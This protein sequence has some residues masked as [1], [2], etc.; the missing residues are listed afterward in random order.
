MSSSWR[1]CGMNILAA[2]PE[3][4]V[5]IH[6]PNFFP[7]L[8]WFAKL[9]RADTMVLLD[10]VQFPKKGGTPTNR[11][12]VL[13]A[14]GPVWVT[15][16]IVRAYHGTRAIN[17]MEI[18][19][20]RPWREK[21][22][23]TIEQAYARAPYL[24]EV[25]P[26]LRE[27]VLNPNSMLAEYNDY[28]IRAIAEA[29]G[30]DTTLLVR[31]SDLNISGDA[32][33]LLISIVQTVAGT[34]YLAGG[35]AGGYQRDELFAERGVDL[36]EQNFAHPLYPQSADPFVPGLSIADALFHCGLERTGDLLT[37]AT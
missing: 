24:A 6:Q 29:I 8:G 27:C 12:K 1:S 4:L 5:A 35:G 16:P 14:P 36:V 13:A 20:S 18:D 31:S 23:S 22:V 15:A 9:A 17:E 25:Q 3:R 28:N 19:E 2:P 7:W 21:L 10:H 26:L 37:N 33:E 34:A 11:V 32:T 30:L